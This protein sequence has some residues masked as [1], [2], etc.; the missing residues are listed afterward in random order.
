M[1]TVGF[2]LKERRLA[3]GLTP[4]DIER[5]IKIR[6]KFIIAIE[7]DHFHLLPSPSYAKGFVRNYAEYLGLSTDQ[8]LAF[9]RRQM[10]E[11]SGASLIPSGV[12]DPLN[13]PLIHLTPGRFIGILISLLLIVFFVYLGGQYYRISQPPVLAVDAPQ[14]QAIV[15]EKHVVV[16]GK[17]DSDAT[18][19]ING[20]SAVVRDDGQFYYQVAVDPGVNKVTITATSKF[21]KTKT[22]VREVG[23]QP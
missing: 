3:R 17:T 10:T 12:A 11:T 7:D 19:M 21:G 9:F 23:Y 8:I 22:I 13:A 1:K 5:A 16:T 6:E 20:V 15:S 18:V 4:A 14:N 2:M